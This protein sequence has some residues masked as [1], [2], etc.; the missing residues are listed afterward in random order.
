MTRRLPPLAALSAF[1]AAAR[2]HGFQRAGEELHVSAGAIAHHVK[3]LEGWLGVALFQ[4]LPRGVALTAAG[5]RY[6]EDV[7]P[8]LDQLAEVSD[9]ARRHGDDQVVTISATTSL[10]TRWLMPRLGRLRDRHPDIELRVLASIRPADLVR[11][12][13]DVAIRLGQGHYP[14]LQVDLLQE[15][16]FC[17]VCSP[18]F[19]AASPKL[20][21]PADLPRHMLLH[22]EPDARIPNEID[23]T[24]WLKSC[25]VAYAGGSG[26][27]FSHTYL[28]LEA[29]AA[30]QGVAL[31][32][33]QLIG[34]D[35]RSGRLL[36]LFEHRLL[37]P[38]RYYLLRTAEAEA[39]PHVRA[40]CEWV[41]EEA[42]ADREA[43]A[44]HEVPVKA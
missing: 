15:E 29:A 34:A 14:G 11:D 35:L 23:W 9:A 6:A 38:Y 2:H 21:T 26:A 20:R 17:A 18:A 3:Q 28:T 1:D 44:G 36:R 16:L 32:T 25:G 7:R 27:G 4:R 33:E 19:L 13:V 10:V 22:D 5:V 30:G 8:L 40:V 41:L 12:G 37:G 42:R 39:R 24:R 43:G 31:G